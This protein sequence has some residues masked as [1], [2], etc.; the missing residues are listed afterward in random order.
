MHEGHSQMKEG[1]VR[2]KKEWR[3]KG[4]YVGGGS[5]IQRVSVGASCRAGVGWNWDER[6]HSK[7]RLT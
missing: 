2:Y 1:A 6:S 5:C 3:Q 7:Q 4:R